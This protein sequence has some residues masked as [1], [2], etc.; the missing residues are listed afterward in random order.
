MVGTRILRL[1]IVGGGPRG[2]AAAEALRARADATRTRISLTLF[3]PH[4][5]IGA[6]PHHDP[7]QTPLNRL[8]IPLRLIDIAP[9]GFPGA[10]VGS[11]QEWAGGHL[12]GVG[13]D[14]YPSR[15]DLGR[16]LTARWHDLVD[17][18]SA[19]FDIAVVRHE[20]K[21]LMRD[22][23]RWR[24][25]TEEGSFGPFD[26]VLLTPGHQPVEPDPQLA[27]WRAHADKTGATLIAAYPSDVL[28][29]A[30]RD[31][32]GHTV[33][34]RGLAL[35]M[36]DVMR[37]LTIGQGGR[38]V[39]SDSGLHYEAS[40]LEP[41]RLLPFSLD[42]VPPAP[43]P[44]SA[45]LDAVYDPDAAEL[46]RFETSL[47]K[48]VAGSA[49]EV[50]ALI[51]EGLAALSAP[52]CERF[53]G[54]EA[55][56]AGWLAIE[57]SEEAEHPAEERPPASILADHLAMA[58][59]RAAPSPG[60]VVGQVWRK[61]QNS[62]RRVYNPAG[63][64]GETATALV[65]FDEGMKR[66]S[67]GPPALA[68]AEML[69]LARSGLLDLRAVDD[70]D[71]AMVQGGWRLSGEKGEATAKVMVDS[72]LPSPELAKL[73]GPLLADLRK[74][75]LLSPVGT[76]LGART[77]GEGCVLDASGNP[78]RGLSMLGRLALGSV[79]ATDSV[80]DCFGASVGRW[81]ESVTG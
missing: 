15:R 49:E 4:P 34:I 59:G 33:A 66:F 56:I 11:F 46:G 6:G 54:K 3:E 40:G 19:Q 67:Y 31:W 1:A 61:L 76:K 58:E 38:F 80:H 37:A 29:T 50:M 25:E 27:R 14:D 69:A 47:A 24:M 75:G 77:T 28:M 7:S 79:I 9:A 2:L 10:H 21:R 42:G 43:K 23:T 22:S 41:A 70:P 65:R 60:Y 72:V 74:Q 32:Q 36:I 62:L 53:G 17:S 35:S 73:S 81:A 55:D 63:I 64:S 51:G 52:V 45:K 8:N 16:F 68:A 71:I 13:P 20:A 12:A 39:R 18:A 30:A 26:E 48:A 5:A 57:L 78:V 44:A